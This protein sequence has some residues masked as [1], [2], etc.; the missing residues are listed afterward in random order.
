[1]DSLPAGLV[2]ASPVALAGSCSLGSV[3]A[4]AGSAAVSYASGATIPAGGC[5]ISVNVTSSTGGSYT[6]TLPAGAL[7][8]DGGSNGQ[9]AVAGLVVQATVPPTVQKAFSPGT[10]NP[11]GTSTLT[12]TLGNASGSAAVLSADLVDTLPAQV[13]VASVPAIGGSCASASV[14]AAAG[15]STV[16]YASGATIP[17]GGCTIQVNVSAAV[18]GGPY[19]NTIAAGALQTSLGSNGAP[20]VANLFVNPAQPPSL[21]KSFSPVQIGVGSSSTLTLSFGNGNA[22]ATTLSADLVDTFPANLLVAAVPN[23]RVGGGCSLASV[24]LGGNTLTY[25]AGAAIPAGGCT[26]SVDVSASTVGSYTN[27]IAAGACR[28]AAAAMR[29][30][31]RPPW[32]CRSCRPWPRASRRPASWP[33]GHVHAHAHAGQPERQ[34]PDLVGGADRHPAFGPGGGRR[35]EPGRQLPGWEDGRGRQPHGELCERCV[36]AFGQLHDHGQRARHRRR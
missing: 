2:L 25:K 33:R 21:S 6:N 29:S 7:S 13:Q 24:V 19:T 36:I 10:V 16:R 34:R 14:T 18:S 30:R 26:V 35:A 4:V 20:A 5:S 1:V 9:P 28:P 22:T 12:I 3:S 31:P 8:T 11:G 15:G 27:T 32:W 17:A 23:L